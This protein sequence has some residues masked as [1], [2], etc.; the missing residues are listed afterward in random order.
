VIAQLTGTVTRVEANSIVLDVNGVGYRVFI[1]LTALASLSVE[2]KRATLHTT[3]T[4][5]ED[6]ITLYGFQTLDEQRIFQL[7]MRVA[8]VGPKLALSM[9]SVFDATELARIISMNDLHSLTKVPGV[10]PKL[11]QR[12]ALE[13]GEKLAELAFERKVEALDTGR[14]PQENQVFEDVVEALVGLG[15]S[16]TDARK[17]A[18]RAQA[19]SDNKADAPRMIAA[20]LRLLTGTR[21]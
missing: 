19:Q 16:R 21:K 15:Y 7:L 3:M 6:D 12:V 11:A 1:P 17:A 4:V 9:L 2:G 20:A 5:R 13:L 10:G 8:G 18:E 14:T